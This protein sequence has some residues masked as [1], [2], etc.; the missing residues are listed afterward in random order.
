MHGSGSGNL[1]EQSSLVR[2]RVSR[3]APYITIVVVFLLS[4]LLFSG[5]GVA[6]SYEPLL[7]GLWQIMD[8][9]LLRDQPL[10]TLWYMHAQPPLFNALIALALQ[11]S[12]DNPDAAFASIYSGLTLAGLFGFYS[13]AMDLLKRKWIA[14]GVTLVVATSSATIL[15]ERALMYEGLVTWLLA[16]GFAC[17][18]QHLVY[19]LTVVLLAVIGAW[20]TLGTPPNADARRL[21]IAILP[22]LVMCFFLYNSVVRDVIFML[23]F[24]CILAAF[25]M[26]WLLV[27][28][29]LESR[30]ATV[31]FALVLADLGSTSVQVVSRT[32]KAFELDA[33]AYLEKVAPDQRVAEV[34]VAANGSI[35]ANIGPNSSPFSY[36]SVVQRVDGHQG[37]TATLVHNYAETI[38]KMAESDLKSDARLSE[39]SNT[40]LGMLNV[41]RV[42]CLQPRRM[43]CPARLLDAMP[44]GPLG[45]VVPVP[46]ATPVLFSTRLVLLQPPPG[47]DKPMFWDEDFVSKP[48]NPRVGETVAFLAKYARKAGISLP[49][50][51]AAAFPVRSLPPETSQSANVPPMHGRLTRYAVSLTGVAMT[52]EADSAGYAQLAHPFFPALAVTINGREVSPLVGSLN[53]MVLPIA[54]GTNAIEIRPFTTPVCVL[55]AAVSA[56]ALAMVLVFGGAAA[57][58]RRRDRPHPVGRKGGL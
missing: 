25:G 37:M 41:T 45:A 9:A 52:I 1:T 50:R 48:Q 36:Y 24:L 55:S 16:L 56:T 33:G 20:S 11:L 21:T 46:D 14:L 40:L 30:L 47:I 35:R 19:G 49:E 7:H 43:G 39:L 12:G 18:W 27:S 17:L 8:V 2:L 38:V 31:A 58:R 4:R 5:L 34:G 28:P 15:Y 51:T 26:Q 57:L 22:C 54:P 6:F 3:V 42:I 44:E 32:D 13:V 23:F 10:Q 53:L 29:G